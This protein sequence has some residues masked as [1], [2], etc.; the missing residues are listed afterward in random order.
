[1]ARRSKSPD[2]VHDLHHV[3]YVPAWWCLPAAALAYAGVQLVLSLVAFSNPV[4][5]SL[6]PSAFLLGCL[7][8]G[9]V[10]L[11]GLTAA[12]KKAGRR[13][14]YDQ[15]RSLESIRALGWR[16]FEQLTG[17]AYRR[18]GYRVTENGG[19]GADGGIDLIL[20]K[21]G[22]RLLVQ[23]KQWRVFKVGVK[24]VRELYGVLMAHRA[25]G[26][27]FVTSGTYTQEA[28]DFAAG[29]PLR[30]VDG[31]ALCRLILPVQAESVVPPLRSTVETM[32]TPAT[33][34]AEE[35]P[36]CP[37]C[38]RTMVRRTATRG[39]NSGARFWGCP[40]YP[41]CRGTRPLAA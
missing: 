16:E 36:A 28:R 7:A 39:H 29:K 10:L 34:S 15:Q 2:L 21:E 6:L 9:V 17:E 35:M 32:A 23:C 8:A 25:D 27:I 13:S 19:G 41:R 14:L 30:L 12:L 20:Q 24:P 18:Q 5:R 26:A 11:A 33:A 37:V 4:Y 40:A 38:E 31:E 1:M 22:E 3:L